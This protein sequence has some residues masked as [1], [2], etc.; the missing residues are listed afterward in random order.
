MSFARLSPKEALHYRPE[1]GVGRVL[2]RPRVAP[3]AVYDSAGTGDVFLFG[4]VWPSTALAP[5]ERSLVTVSALVAMGR[6]AQ[7]GGHVDR[8]VDHGVKPAEIGE[9]IT[10]LA[11]YSG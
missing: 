2:E 11:F 6:I 7:V 5:R 4:E 10:H 3:P 1:D 9:L 8:A